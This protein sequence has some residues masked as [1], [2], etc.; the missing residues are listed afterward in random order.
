MAENPQYLFEEVGDGFAN[1]NLLGF[2]AKIGGD[3]ADFWAKPPEAEKIV[4]SLLFGMSKNEPGKA[5]TPNSM[6]LIVPKDTQAAIL[7]FRMGDSPV[8]IALSSQALA[9]LQLEIAQ[10]EKALS[11][12]AI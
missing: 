8:K 1:E 2:E 5:W 7:E 11:K 4:L 3:M 12:R 10:C 9:R 6:R